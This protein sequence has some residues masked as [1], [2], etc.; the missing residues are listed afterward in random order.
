LIEQERLQI[1]YANLVELQGSPDRRPLIFKSGPKTLDFGVQDGVV[2]ID[3]PVENLSKEEKNRLLKLNAFSSNFGRRDPKNNELISYKAKYHK[4]ELNEAALLVEKI[5]LEVFRVPLDYNVTFN[6]QVDRGNVFNRL[7]NK[8]NQLQSNKKKDANKRRT[9]EYIATNVTFVDSWSTNE[10]VFTDGKFSSDAMSK[11]EPT[12]SSSEVL[13]S[14]PKKE[15]D[16]NN[17]DGHQFETLIETLVKKMGFTIKE[18]KLTADGGIDM[19]AQSHESLFQGKYVIQ[20]K[21]Y[22]NKI[23]VSPI[24]D[25]YGVVHSVNANK[26]ILITNSTFTQAALDFAIDK[27]LELIDGTKLA[28]LLSKHDLLKH[29]GTTSFSDSAT[30]LLYNFLPNMKKIRDTYEDIKNGKIFMESIPVDSDYKMA[31]L[32]NEM[33]ARSKEFYYWWFETFK[34]FGFEL[35]MRTPP[36]NLQKINERNHQLVQALQ[37]YL[38]NYERYKRICPLKRFQ[39]VYEI[40]LAIFEDIFTSVFK[41]IEELEALAKL[42]EEEL[43]QKI[44]Q[45]GTININIKAAFPSHLVKASL[46]AWR[47]S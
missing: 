29:G 17:M 10:M 38:K 11:T 36:P 16:I 13:K 33:V 7:L 30:Y 35:S 14:S 24:R 44:G 39:N 26:G 37:K 41:I 46:E 1:F 15:F 45:K 31:H 40:H 2:F 47:D 42:P 18:R 12:P 20:C 32:D 5:F 19:L 6:F 22:N 23:P 4:F 8:N 27:Q 28:G 21:R 25:L 34:N 3:L 9:S 43:K